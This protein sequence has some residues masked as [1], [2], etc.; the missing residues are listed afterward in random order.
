M[1]SSLVLSRGGR[2]WLALGAALAATLALLT[3][4]LG[5]SQ[6]QQPVTYL[7][8][9][10]M[11]LA[12][13][14]GHAKMYLKVGAST[15]HIPIS[16]LTLSVTGPV[17]GGTLSSPGITASRTMDAHSVQLMS[18]MTNGKPTT[19]RFFVNRVVNGKVVE[20]LRIAMAGGQTWVTSD[21]LTMSKSGGGQEKVTFQA[22]K[23]TLDYYVNGNLAVTDQYTLP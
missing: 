10:G 7:G 15:V 19:A 11:E 9:Q 17:G 21:R 16:T 3:G 6:S 5:K 8:M 4:P 14:S 18:F 2:R 13:F 12:A 20:Q 22:P 23:V 1:V